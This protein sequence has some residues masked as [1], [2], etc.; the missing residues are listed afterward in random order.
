MKK[1]TFRECIDH[2]LGK[3]MLCFGIG[4]IIGGLWYLTSN[5]YVIIKW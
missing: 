3:L 1:W 5:H 4:L 2:P